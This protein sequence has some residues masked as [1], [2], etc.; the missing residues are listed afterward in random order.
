[1]GP[2]KVNIYFLYLS[3]Y[4]C[5]HPVPLLFQYRT[6]VV[7]YLSISLFLFKK[8]KLNLIVLREREKNLI[9][10]RLSSFLSRLSLKRLSRD[11]KV[12]ECF[13]TLFQTIL[14]TFFCESL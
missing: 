14:K 8:F 13:S 11:V 4:N 9:R 7:K 6:R 12:A 2:D 5:I 3:L 1:M 10:E